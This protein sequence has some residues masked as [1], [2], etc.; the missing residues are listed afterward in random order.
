MLMK[1][2]RMCL[3]CSF[4]SL[5]HCSTKAGGW[6]IPADFPQCYSVKTG[7][8]SLLRYLGSLPRSKEGMSL[9]LAGLK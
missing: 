4:C 2:E 1:W 9:L 7:Y 6:E 8:Y 5:Q 3:F